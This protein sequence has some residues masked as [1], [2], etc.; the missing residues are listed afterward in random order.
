MTVD[1]RFDR[2]EQAIAGLSQSIDRLTQYVLD[3]RKETIMQFRLLESRM[4]ML[5]ARMTS[6]E[7]R[8]PSPV[9]GQAISDIGAAASKM[10]V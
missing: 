10:L 7:A 4:D 3:F 6:I 1:E 2:V 5:D 8:Q 9:F